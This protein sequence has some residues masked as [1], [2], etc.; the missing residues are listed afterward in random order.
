MDYMLDQYYSLH[1]WDVDT[2]H[3]TKEVLAALGLE[4]LCSDLKGLGSGT[5]KQ[6]S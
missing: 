6:Q 1:G 2:G 3:P 5:K 4:S